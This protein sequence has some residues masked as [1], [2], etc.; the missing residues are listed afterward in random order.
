M[1]GYVEHVKKLMGESGIS[2]KELSKLSGI[3]EASVSRYLSGDL[4]PRID[5]LMNFAK[6]FDVSVS[7]LLG[8]EHANQ[9]KDSPFD[10]TLCVVARNKSKLT[11]EQKS[12]LIKVLYGGK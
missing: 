5:V 9:E 7:Y 11:D 1:N 4:N 10:E 12:D 3:S 6:V 8:D 2:Q